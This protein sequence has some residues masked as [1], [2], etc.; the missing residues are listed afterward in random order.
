VIRTRGGDRG[1]DRWW[2][3]GGVGSAM[4]QLGGHRRV[5]GRQIIADGDDDALS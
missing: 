1:G 5:V 3:R 2:S 4:R